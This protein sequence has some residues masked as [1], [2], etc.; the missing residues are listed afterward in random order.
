MCGLHFAAYSRTFGVVGL[1]RAEMSLETR[2][3]EIQG[4]CRRRRAVPLGATVD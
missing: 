1:G 3:G 4:A 2:A